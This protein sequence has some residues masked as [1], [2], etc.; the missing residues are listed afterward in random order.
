[1][2]QPAARLKPK[3][4]IAQIKTF[5]APVS[6]WIANQNL[7]VPNALKPDGTRVQGAAVL[8]NWFPTAT[9]IRMRG[10]S[11]VFAQIGDAS[12]P[13]VTMFSYVVGNNAKLFATTANAIYDITNPVIPENLIL[14]DDLGNLLVDD[15]GRY[16]VSQ[17]SVP[18]FEVGSLSGGDWSVVQYATTGGTFLRC[19]NGVDTPLIYDG[20]AWTTVPA[21]TGV[22]PTTLSFVWVYKDRL[23]FIQK[24]TLDVWYLPVNSIGG[25]A[26]KFPLGGVFTRGGSLLFGSVWSIESGDGPS[27]QIVFVTTEGEVAVY[28]GDDPSDASNFTKIGVFRIGKPRGP[29]AFIR[30]GGDLIIATDIGLVPLSQAFQRDVAAL[31]QTAISYAIEIE[32]NKVVAE[33]S[34]DYWHTE[35]WPTKQM[36]LVAPP[37][38]E[39]LQPRLMVANAR[40]GAWAPFT[41]WNATCLNLFGDRFFFGSDSGKIVECEVTGLD[42]GS[43]YTCTYVP[44]FDPL[45]NPAALKVGIQARAVLRATSKPNPKMSLQSD[46]SVSL[47]A[48]PDDT[49]LTADNLWGVGVW[50]VS[51]WGT[52]SQKKTFQEW[53]SVPGSG[54]SLAAATQIT[55]GNISPPDVELVQT[56]LTYDMGDIGS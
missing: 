7:L 43:S 45:K 34:V 48:A 54:Y 31:S 17:F 40:T 44:L 16:L 6:G 10:G 18:D 19:V 5:P 47:P 14:A 1:V 42:Q 8:E 49:T 2:R 53:R 33:R 35:L 38:P 9:G 11:K 41:G 37:T 36:M 56:D 25:V 28:R 52:A 15:L 32:W 4:R 27:E 51:K 12:L 55:S 26:V 39:G 30:A 46:Y 29:K 20:T 21:I 50:G 13:V 3:P 23:F 22:D 24:D